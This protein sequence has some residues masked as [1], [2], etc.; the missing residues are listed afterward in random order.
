MF[1]KH[2]D[3]QRATYFV[4]RGPIFLFTCFGEKL[5]LRCHLPAKTVESILISESDKWKLK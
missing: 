5:F 1:T 2:S 3:F 4:F